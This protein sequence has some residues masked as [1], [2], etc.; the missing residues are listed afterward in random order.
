[1]GGHVVKRNDTVIRY[2]GG[3]CVVFPFEKYQEIWTRLMD[4]QTR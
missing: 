3:F 1:M 2:A 4:Q